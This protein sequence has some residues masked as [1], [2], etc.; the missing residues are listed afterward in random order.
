[1]I[2]IELCVKAHGH[3]E[4]DR[5]DAWYSVTLKGSSDADAREVSEFKLTLKS[6]KE[7][8]FSSYP[9]GKTVSLKL[10]DPQRKL[11]GVS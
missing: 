11:D 8:I 6:E 3:G 9:I 2:E 4:T 7:S 5:K 10:H 1:M